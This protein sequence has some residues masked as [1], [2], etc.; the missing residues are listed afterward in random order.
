MNVYIKQ[1]CSH[2]HV[3]VYIYITEQQERH[4][5]IQ[6]DGVK[7]YDNGMWVQ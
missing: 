6:F 3:Y 1:F 2:I 7:K 5:E 4:S